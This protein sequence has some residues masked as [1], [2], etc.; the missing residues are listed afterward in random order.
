MNTKIGMRTIWGNWYSWVNYM[1]NCKNVS[2]TLVTPK[3][4]ILAT[5]KYNFL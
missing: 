5:K 3:L 4:D 2:F 1:N